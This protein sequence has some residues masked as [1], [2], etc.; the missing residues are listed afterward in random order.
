ME[1]QPLEFTG[2]T[3]DHRPLDLNPGWMN[4]AGTLGFAPPAEWPVPRPPVAFVTNPISYRPRKPAQDRALISYPGGFLLHTGWPSPGIREVIRRYA[5]RWAR[6]P[7]PIWVHLLGDTPVH[8]ERMVRQ[9]EELERVTAIELSFP[10]RAAGAEIQDYILAA[11][12]EL[13]LI[14]AVPLDRV[15]ESGLERAV[16]LGLSAVSMAPPRG[17]LPAASGSLVRGRLYG[18][19]LLAQTRSA[20]EYLRVFGLPVIAGG[21]VIRQAEID[22]LIQIGAACVQLDFILWRGWPPT[23]AD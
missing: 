14:L 11:L 21:G 17:A 7:V 20:L 12:G 16:D 9:I 6:S 3:P 10:Y 2:M 19:A 8:I 13:P 4:A 23:V 1:N 15:R 22:E 18:P 5:Q